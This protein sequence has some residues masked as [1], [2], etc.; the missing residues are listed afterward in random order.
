MIWIIVDGAEA[1]GT[2]HW[3]NMFLLRFVAKDGKENDYIDIRG[4]IT[5]EE[6]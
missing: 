2:N 3:Q 5:E 6:Y 1:F 4:N